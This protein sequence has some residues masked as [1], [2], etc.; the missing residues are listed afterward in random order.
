MSP[1]AAA[2]VAAGKKVK[3]PKKTSENVTTL[4][5][6]SLLLPIKFLEIM[7]TSSILIRLLSGRTTEY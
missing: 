6:Q 2:W 5:G 3:K 7:F 1:A 4:A